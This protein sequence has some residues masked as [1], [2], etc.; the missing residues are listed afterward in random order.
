MMSR[1]PIFFF[2][3]TCLECQSLF[4]NLNRFNIRDE[5]VAANVGIPVVR[6]NAPFKL[7]E[8]PVIVD[9]KDGRIYTGGQIPKFI[10]DLSMKKQ[11]NIDPKM[12]ATGKSNDPEPLTFSAGYGMSWL[13]NDQNEMSPI[14]E[15]PTSRSLAVSALDRDRELSVNNN[16]QRFNTRTTDMMDRQLPT[17]NS[18]PPAV[19]N[20]VTKSPMDNLRMMRDTELNT[21]R[22]V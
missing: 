12:D 16:T 14:N 5:F 1:K 9:P 21:W 17:L 13:D 15:T 18:S 19:N 3:D 7:D 22:N 4:E 10:A 11:Y 6:E 2:S 20:N 8:I